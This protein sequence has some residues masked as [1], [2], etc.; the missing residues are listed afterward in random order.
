MLGRIDRQMLAAGP[1]A[2]YDANAKMLLGEKIILA[3][4]T[5]G[6]CGR[7]CQHG[8]TGDFRIHRGGAGGYHRFRLN[9]E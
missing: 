9:R 2:R 5:G 3:A 6:L 7:I 1:E 4:Y 8:S